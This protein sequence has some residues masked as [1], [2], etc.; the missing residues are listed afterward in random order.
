MLRPLVRFAAAGRFDKRVVTFEIRHQ[1]VIQLLGIW[2]DSEGGP[3]LMVMPL[4]ENGS[5]LAYLR[6]GNVGATHCA[7]ILMGSALGLLHLH[8]MLPRIIHGDIHPNNI[9]VDQGGNA[10]IC[11]FGFSRIRHDVTRTH[12]KIRE[13]GRARFLA[14]ELLDGPQEFRTTT[15]S[16]VYSLSLTFFNLVTLDTPFSQYAR[17][18][19]AAAASQRGERPSKPDNP[20][21]FTLDVFRSLWELL[22]GMWAHDPLTRP[23][24][25]RVSDQLQEILGPLA[26][27]AQLDRNTP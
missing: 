12:S 15:S 10:L 8:S 20:H 5:A 25:K 21:F 9:V 6:R 11:D 14:P 3:P 26:P 17:D 24:A 18:L 7:E 4:A 13:G 22:E 23:N 16:D 1:N 2:R 27:R 19:A